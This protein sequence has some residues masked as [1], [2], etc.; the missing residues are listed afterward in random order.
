MICDE[1]R[2]TVQTPFPA[3][4]FDEKRQISKLVET[5][6]A[7]SNA[8]QR[9]GRAGRVQEGLAFHLFTKLRHDTQMQDHPLPEMLRLSLQDLALRIKILKV[10]M[11]GSIEEVL[12]KALDPPLSL[13]IQRGASWLPLQ[14]CMSENAEF[15]P[16]FPCIAVSSLVEVKALTAN[17]D[18]TPMGRLLSKLPVRLVTRVDPIGGG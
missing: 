17:E 5:W 3:G 2:L 10:K 18:I 1:Q 7:K 6:V 12:S 14:K 11:G 13:N 16:P 9:R 15:P 8:A 4:R